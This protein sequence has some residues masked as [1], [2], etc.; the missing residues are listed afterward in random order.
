[1]PLS[2]PES[3]PRGMVTLPQFAP[4]CVPGLGS[5][6]EI[7]VSQPV[8]H[9][10]TSLDSRVERQRRTV[11]GRHLTPGFSDDQ[12]GRCGVMEVR[13]LLYGAHGLS[14][15]DHHGLIASARNW[16]DPATGTSNRVDK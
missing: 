4:L 16:L 7:L 11:E 9:D 2:T 6:D 12:C 3:M 14:A 10:H 13:S 1:M 15:C 8:G 5:L